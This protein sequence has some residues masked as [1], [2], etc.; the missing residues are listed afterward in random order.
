M[1]M[2]SYSVQALAHQVDLR[3]IS[4]DWAGLSEQH[5]QSCKSASQT[6]PCMVFDSLLTV[7]KHKLVLLLPSVFHSCQQGL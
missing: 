6:L 4:L 3:N 1:G 5:K 2:T 7:S